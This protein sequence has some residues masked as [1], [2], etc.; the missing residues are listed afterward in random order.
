[1][2]A[3]LVT[4]ADARE[5]LRRLATVFTVELRMKIV[6]ELYMR[7]MSAKQFFNE[8]GGGSP[9]RIS[10]NFVALAKKGW[11]RWLYCDGP[12]EERH[13]GVEHFFRATELPFMDADSWALLPYSVRLA[14]SRN[15]F[16]QIAPR[17]REDVEGK[18]AG[19]RRN[20][21]CVQYSLD[22]EGW[23]RVIDGIR[24]RFARLYEEQADARHRCLLTG[25]ELH[26]ADVFLIGFQSSGPMEIPTASDLLLANPREPLAPFAQ[27]LAPILKDDV[28]LDIAWDLNRHETSVTQF[29]REIG[30]A[31]KPGVS[32]RFKGLERGGWIAKGKSL[33]GG[34]RRSAREQ[35][36]HAT[37]PALDD[38]DPCANPASALIREDE[39]GAFER[40][41]R[42]VQ[43]AMLCGALDARTDRALT[44]SL[45]SLDHQGWENVFAE[46]ESLQKL[47]VD[48]ERQAKLR[49]AKSGQ[50]PIKMTVGLGAFEAPEELA[51]AP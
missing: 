13:G 23:N 18:K 51:K 33:T 35:F 47:A 2:A 22:E 17:L 10:Q 39:W 29:H 49:M 4:G 46:I 37:K 40:L 30:G 16:R 48:E 6:V 25:V 15:I 21:T 38:Y 34:A 44:W 43:Q 1:M 8:F 42:E 19:Y 26:R 32:R 14:S 24:T 31:S 20:L 9:A 45:V 50:R 41:C 5:R 7:E 3:M 27:R 36:F 12:G 11:L 28:M